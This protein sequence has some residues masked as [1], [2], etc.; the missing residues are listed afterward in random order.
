MLSDCYLGSLKYICMDGL[1]GIVFISYRGCLICFVWYCYGFRGII[2][3]F[4]IML[5]VMFSLKKSDNRI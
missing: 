2:V 3:V 4:L 5:E 1:L